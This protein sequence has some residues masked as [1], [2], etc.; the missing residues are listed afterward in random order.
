MNLV[1]Q[2]VLRVGAYMIF[3]LLLEGILPNGNSKRI[4]KLMLGLVFMY[5]LIQPISAWIYQEIPLAQLTTAEIAWSQMEEN[6]KVDY[7]TQALDMVGNGYEQLLMT[8]GL[9]KDLE[10]TYAIEK[11]KVADRVEITLTRKDAIGSFSNRSLEFGTIG[12]SKEEEES[13]IQSISQHWGVAEN[14]LEMKIR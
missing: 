6:Q 13:V 14:Q 11:I 9:P 10:K 1:S 7:E 2:Y 5:V 12:I 8:E 3:S 4:I